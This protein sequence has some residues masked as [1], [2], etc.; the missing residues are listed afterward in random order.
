MDQPWTV[1]GKLSIVT[2]SNTGLGRATA[3]ELARRGSSVILASRSKERTAPALTEIAGEVGAD[4]VEFLQLD[5]ASL[6]SVKKAT[7]TF[8]SSGRPLHLLVNNAGLAGRRGIT[9][10]GFELTFGVNYLGHYLLTRLLLDRIVASAPARI[11]HVAS[12]VHH[13]AER[14]NWDRLR[15]RRLLPAASEYA[16]SKLANLLFN[17]ELAKRLIGTRVTTYAAHPG[18]A[19][20]DIYRV[21]PTPLRKLIIRNMPTPEDAAKTQVWCATA[22]EL[23]EESGLYYANLEEKEP[24]PAARDAELAAELWSK[25]EAWV[26]EF[27]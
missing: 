14:I 17:S 20:T 16:V 15:E 7:E 18:L 4:R 2:G 12:S 23:S 24:S 5:L 9:A 21:V 1:D 10:E 6:A 3:L 8:L 22:P 13:R 26:S 19:A 25:S 27:L 11:V